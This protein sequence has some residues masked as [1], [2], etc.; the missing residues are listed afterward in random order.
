[1]LR[2]IRGEIEDCL[3]PTQLLTTA[4]FST[5]VRLIP[6][7]LRYLKENNR[8]NKRKKKKRKKEKERYPNESGPDITLFEMVTPVVEKTRMLSRGEFRI[9]L[10]SIV[11]F[12]APPETALTKVNKQMKIK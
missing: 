9:T 1:L 7:K 6:G 5:F 10:F 12:S 2:E 4:A 3:F 8:K 11:R